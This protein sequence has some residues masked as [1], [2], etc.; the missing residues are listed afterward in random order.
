MKSSLA[1]KNHRE[2]KKW[3]LGSFERISLIAQAA[4][5]QEK[6]R[7]LKASRARGCL[8][9]NQFA[10]LKAGY[11]PD[12]S[13]EK[14]IRLKYAVYIKSPLW[15]QRRSKYW[16]KHEREC[17]ACHARTGVQLHH[18]SYESLGNERDEHLIA[19]CALHHKDFHQ[20]FGVDFKMVR[21]TRRYVKKV[22][23]SGYYKLKQ[24]KL[25]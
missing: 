3:P 12:L 22:R 8:S 7:I 18:A 15:M 14:P 21:R 23:K 17:A 24:P 6:L 10:F 1:K 16:E 25:L 19:L 2:A 13:G 11:M 5:P 9:K 4:S 20:N